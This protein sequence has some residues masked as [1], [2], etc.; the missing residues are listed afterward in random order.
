MCQFL[1][2]SYNL[3]VVLVYY[4]DFEKAKLILQWKW[5]IYSERVDSQ[6]HK[7]TLQ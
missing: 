4:L 7:G 2:E 6:W 5:V 3:F 1:I